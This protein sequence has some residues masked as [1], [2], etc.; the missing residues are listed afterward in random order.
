MTDHEED[1]I[2]SKTEGFKVGEKKTIAEYNELGMCA[3]DLYI[4][5]P[6]ASAPLPT[7][8]FMLHNCPSTLISRRLCISND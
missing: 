7:L 3:L 5:P 2:A 8:P 4:C 1:L 6:F